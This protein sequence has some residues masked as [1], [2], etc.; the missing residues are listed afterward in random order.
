LLRRKALAGYCPKIVLLGIIFA[1]GLRLQSLKLTPLG[2]PR[3]VVSVSGYD[4]P[5]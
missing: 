5:K 3:H 4:D 1:A 2:S